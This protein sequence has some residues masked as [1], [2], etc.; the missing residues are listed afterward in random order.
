ML[1]KTKIALVAALLAGTATAAMAQDFDPNLA[2][3]Y[4]GYAS[5]APRATL[6]SAPV[7]LNQSVVTGWE[8]NN[9]RVPGNQGDTTFGGDWAQSYGGGF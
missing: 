2:N 3:R 9:R 6:Q 4:P 7:R 5:T 1:T 8:Q